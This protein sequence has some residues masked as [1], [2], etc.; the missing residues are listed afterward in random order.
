MKKY[1]TFNRFILIGVIALTNPNNGLDIDRDEETTVTPVGPEEVTFKSLTVSKK[2]DKIM[3]EAGEVFDP[4]GMELSA[5]YSDG[6]SETITEGYTC[7]FITDEEITHPLDK[8]VNQIYH[9]IE[10][11]EFPFVDSEI[12]GYYDKFLKE[13]NQ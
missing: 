7:S 11:K 13:T 12:Q 8:S 1:L 2:P 9:L 10:K 3:Y 5:N 6:T 4:T